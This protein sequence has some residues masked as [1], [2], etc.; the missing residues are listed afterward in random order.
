MSTAAQLSATFP[1]VSSAAR[2]PARDT[3]PLASAHFVDGGY[4]DNDGTSSAIEFLR[5]A[6]DP[7]PAP[8]QSSP[9]VRDIEQANEFHTKIKLPVKILLI[10]I[11][12]S[13]DSDV[14]GFPSTP[15]ALNPPKQPNR[16]TARPSGV[17]QQ[18]EFPPQG[19]WSAGHG[20]VT[21]RNRNGL[22]LLVQSH[23]QSLQLRQIVFDD[24]AQPGQ[25]LGLQAAQDPLSWS[26]TPRQRE[27][28]TQ[29]ADR[30]GWLK[31]CY[32]DVVGLLSGAGKWQ[33][34]QSPKRC[35]P[36][37]VAEVTCGNRRGVQR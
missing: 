29:N 23:P 18:L 37:E 30:S 7:P 12:N 36:H 3:E 31:E 24:H 15:S 28:V 4:Y 13:E 16:K 21:G 1:Y 19:L 27:E 35:K 9:A 22:D 6:L 34:L 2:I 17:L 8:S 11:R 26:L 33:D 5:Y 25:C 14:P 32:E 20:S 10:E